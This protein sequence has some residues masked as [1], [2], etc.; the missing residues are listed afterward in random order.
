[1]NPYKTITLLY[2]V[3]SSVEMLQRLAAQMDPASAKQLLSNMPGVAAEDPT[4]TSRV[5]HLFTVASAAFGAMISSGGD[6]SI[7][8]NGESG[9]GKTEACKVLLR[10][11][12]AVSA[13]F[14]NVAVRPSCARP[15]PHP[16]R[17]RT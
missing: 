3:P 1:M 10:Y 6:Q 9:A 2:E 4:A 11:L 13:A 8:V 12:A 7:I 16:T 17:V 15:C 14:A 5:P